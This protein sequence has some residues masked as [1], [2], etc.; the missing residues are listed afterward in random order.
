V[1]HEVEHDG[2]QEER[3]D[4]G[5]RDPVCSVR[6]DRVPDAAPPPARAPDDRHQRHQRDEHDEL[7][8]AVDE[9]PAGE[10]EHPEEP[11]VTRR[12]GRA[13]D[14]E[15]DERREV[16]VR[17]P[18]RRKDEIVRAREHDRDGERTDERHA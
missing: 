7:D 15:G 4:C 1:Q 8:V 9:E 10:G 16:D 2:K 13:C 3:D 5:E 12:D 11:C 18:R 17:H 14:E 6:D